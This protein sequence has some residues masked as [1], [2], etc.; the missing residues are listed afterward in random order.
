MTLDHF[1]RKTEFIRNNRNWFPLIS[2]E[3]LVKLDLLR[4]RWGSGIHI[5]LNEDAIGRELGQDDDSKHNFDKWGEVLAIDVFPERKGTANQDAL[6]AY[7][8]Q[9]AKECGFRGIGFY[10]EWT[11]QKGKKL[12]KGGFHLDVRRDRK[13]GDPASWGYTKNTGSISISN[14]IYNRYL[15]GT[16]NEQ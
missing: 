14:F 3:L 8:F 16:T 9:L 12:L 10:P 13:A 5:S 4:Y 15:V 7:F 11:M 1:D 2:K 6:N